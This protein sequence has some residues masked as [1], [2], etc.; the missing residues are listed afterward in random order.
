MA[1]KYSALTELLNLENAD[2]LCVSE[3]DGVS[4]YDS[5]KITWQTLKTS[6]ISDGTASNQIAR[7]NGT[8]YEGSSNLLFDNSTSTLNV[9][10]GANTILSISG[11]GLML[12][13]SSGVTMLGIGTNNFAFIKPTAGTYFGCNETSFSF[14]N[15]TGT[16]TIYMTGS[17]SGIRFHD[18]YTF[19]LTNGTAGQ[20]LTDTDGNGTLTWT[21]AAGGIGGSI[22]NTQIAYGNGTAIAG[23]NNFTWNDT[24]KIL[25]IKAVSGSWS[26]SF[27][28]FKNASDVIRSQMRSNGHLV[29]GGTPPTSPFPDGGTDVVSWIPLQVISQGNDDA[30]RIWSSSRDKYLSIWA[31]SAYTQ[32]ATTGNGSLWLGVAQNSSGIASLGYTFDGIPYLNKVGLRTATITT[33]FDI[34]AIGNT[35]IQATTS[36]GLT[37]KTPA[38]TGN[39]AFVINNGSSI[40][41]IR[42]NGSFCTNDIHNTVAN[43]GFYFL[44]GANGSNANLLLIRTSAVYGIK[45]DATAGGSYAYI[46]SSYSSFKN[47]YDIYLNSG[48]LTT[49]IAGVAASTLTQGG[50]AIFGGYIKTAYPSLNGAG[51]WKLGKK[52]TATVSLV[53]TDYIE[54][55]IDGVDYKLALATV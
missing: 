33:G 15:V 47:N 6:I 12:A 8:K 40:F 18:Q 14:L 3:Y 36:G 43:D 49:Y 32:I 5:K 37:I 35:Q 38:A 29:L 10:N 39:D 16:P 2:L 27:I 22:A 7:W 44:A 26:D 28:N 21:N 19:P 50:N 51:Q 54:V 30:V 42:D 20:V 1:V 41:T 52:I 53:T 17:M 31:N 23:S 24:N 45:I 34:D 46:G 55:E 48:N 13:N 25:N 11:S 4:A 9:K